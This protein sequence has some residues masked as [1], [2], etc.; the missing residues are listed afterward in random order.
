VKTLKPRLSTTSSRLASVPKPYQLPTYRIRGRRLMDRRRRYLTAH[1][2]CE[3]CKKH[4]RASIAVELDHVIPLC[5][6]GVDDETNLAALCI[7]CHQAKTK[8]DM[9]T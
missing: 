1:P 4:H 6:G 5:K 9:A 3:E 7:P 2:L 8:Q